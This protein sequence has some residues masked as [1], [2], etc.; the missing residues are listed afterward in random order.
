[1]FV[2]VPFM[3]EEVELGGQVLNRIVEFEDQVVDQKG[4]FSSFLLAVILVL[5]SAV[6]IVSSVI[7]R[8]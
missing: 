3:Y 8:Q 5:C 1:M 6:I 4:N 7:S 2:N